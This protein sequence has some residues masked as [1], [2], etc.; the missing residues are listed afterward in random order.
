MLSYLISGITIFFVAAFGSFFTAKNSGSEWYKCIKPRS[1]TPPAFVFPIVWTVLYVLLFLAFA[2]SIR[3]KYDMIN[4]L[5]VL[6]FV[7]NVLW[8]YFYFYKK[9]PDHA[10]IIIVLMVIANFMQVWFAYRKKDNH[11]MHMLIPHLLWITFAMILNILSI[12]KLKLC[13]NLS[14]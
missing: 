12:L 4:V 1:I 13:S 14:W 10:L 8:C 11:L 7:L 5:F 3:Q 6:I 2:H 9:N